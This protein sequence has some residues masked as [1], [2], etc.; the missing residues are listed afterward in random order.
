MNTPTRPDTGNLG[1]AIQ[2][3]SNFFP[4]N[5]IPNRVIYHYSVS[6][7]PDVPPA[8]N[9]NI[10]LIWEKE[11]NDLGLLNGIKPVYDG[12]H[13]MYSPEPVFSGEMARYQV[14]YYDEDEFPQWYD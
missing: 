8:K 11:S 1:S 4:L 5:T 13:N 9:R 6:I 7:F 10:F 12:R 14:D 2:V 3:R